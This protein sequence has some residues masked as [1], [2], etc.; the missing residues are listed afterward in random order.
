M[1]CKM[2]NKKQE[3]CKNTATITIPIESDLNV[4]DSKPDVKQ[5]IY[6]K[7]SGKVEEVKT[8]SNKVWVKGKI[9]YQIIY[10]TEKAQEPL[11][12]IFGEIPFMEEIYLEG[13]DAQD[14]AVVA[15]RIENEK[16]QIINSRKLSIHAKVL[17]Q[18]N[19]FYEWRQDY[20]CDMEIQ[21]EE[22]VSLPQVEYQKREVE[23]LETVVSKKDLLRIHEEI[24]LPSE[25]GNV[26]NA[27]WKSA[28]LVFMNFHC[29]DEKLVA[30]G[31]L[32]ILL[33]YQ[34]EMKE[35]IWNYQHTMPV[36]QTFPCQECEEGMICDISY[37]VTQEEIEIREDG[38][39]NN[40][41]LSVEMAI[42]LD[43]KLW[44]KKK[45]QLLSDLYGINCEISCTKNP[46]LFL[47][48][49]TI[50][51]TEQIVTKK[52]VVE[53]EMG[54]VIYD[55][56]CAQVDQS[57]A[58]DGQVS[59]WGRVA[60]Y[61]LCRTKT[62]DL[63]EHIEAIPFHFEVPIAVSQKGMFCK[64][65]VIGQD[66]QA[67]VTGDF[68]IEYTTELSIEI[69]VLEEVSCDTIQDVEV[70][71]L[72]QEKYDTIPGMT[73]YVVQKGDTLWNIG[74]QYYLS[75]ED[76]KDINKM[77]D[78]RLVDGDKLILMKSSVNE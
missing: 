16:V 45:I 74:K 50:Q 3:M 12:S 31:E 24:E 59:M 69:T 61:T 54:E 11:A 34:E 77:T 8:G 78:D 39:G 58:E 1:K 21:P 70:L 55:R 49:V 67:K 47:N 10:Q 53:N 41:V 44:K 17:L 37:H 29:F 48:Y 32:G 25:Y 52:S 57:K 68:E 13:V 9:L 51:N 40:R 73:V 28:D 23:D 64:C 35:K 30:T 5:I 43:M 63:F 60:H 27:Y 18:A 75:I 76:I 7:M 26:D 19:D 15:L 66:N 71:P 62:G 20:S 56:A 2:E 36:N 46:V 65:N 42:E 22:N 72:D 33:I 6:D 4:A 38:D 14:R